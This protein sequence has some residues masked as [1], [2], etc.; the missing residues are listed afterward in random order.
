MASFAPLSAS[1]S[2]GPGG[3]GAVADAWFLGVRFTPLTQAEARAVVVARP[4]GAEFAYV[5]T[6]NAQHA[7]LYDRGGGDL[8]A[9]Q[10]NAW[11]SLLDSRVMRLIARHLFRLDLPVATGSDLCAAL[12]A[13]DIGPDDPITVI[14]GSDELARRLCAR[15]GLRRLAMHI[16]PMGFINDAAEV[17]RC[18]DFVR[19]HPARFVFIACGFPR[20]ELLCVMLRQAG[21]ITGTGLCVGASLLFLAGLVRRAPPFWGRFGLEWLYRILQEPRRLLPRLFQEQLPVLA[22]ALRHWRAG[23]QAP[24]PRAAGGGG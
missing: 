6:P 8:R 21:G 7:V 22:L 5:I 13:G 23:S 11:L 17:A 12:F 18:I 9:I 19:A 4:A 16:P 24:L 15:Y 14:G 1:P 20:S 10:D 3:V 2:P